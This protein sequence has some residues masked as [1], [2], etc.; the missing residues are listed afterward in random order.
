MSIPICVL[1]SNSGIIS[2]KSI[3]YYQNIA[4]YIDKKR[5]TLKK[6]TKQKQYDFESLVTLP[7]VENSRIIFEWFSN[8]S[9]NDKVTICSIHNKWLAKIINQLIIV[10]EYENSTSL[11]P[12]GDFRK[13]FTDKEPSNNY[14]F[15]GNKF[16]NSYSNT[17][18]PEGNDISFFRYFFK[19]TA[20]AQ[21]KI[22]DKYNKS[23]LNN[24]KFFNYEEA[25]DT[26][27]ISKYLLSKVDDFKKYFDFYSSHNFLKSSIEPD[28]S[29]T[30]KLYN[31]K[32]P[33]WLRNKQ[34]FTIF[35]IIVGYI[36]QNILLNYE[37]YYY[38]KKIYDNK[39][40]EKINEIEELNL[41][42]E[43][44]LSQEFKDKDTF[45]SKINNLQIKKRVQE[46]PLL[47]SEFH[48]QRKMKCDIFAL[49]SNTD[50]KILES[51][52]DRMI[53][54]VIKKMDEWFQ[55]SISELLYNLCFVSS[56]DVASF[57]RPLYA[58]TFS[59]LAQLFQNKNAN[60]LIEE[61]DNQIKKKKKHKKKKKKNEEN[62]TNK[63]NNINNDIKN[64]NETLDN[65]IN[66]IE[67][68]DDKEITIIEENIIQEK[69]L[70][71][72]NVNTKNIIQNENEDDKTKK[73]GKK[74]KQKKE[75]FLYP[76]HQ[77]KKKKEEHKENEKKN[78]FGKPNS[79][80]KTIKEIDINKEKVLLI[81][82]SPQTDNSTIE[83]SE[84]YYSNNN[85]KN[86]KIIYMNNNQYN[87]FYNPYYTSQI[88]AFNI[89][90]NICF[91]IPSENFFTKLTLELEIYNSNVKNNISKLNPIKGIYLE[92]L[93]KILKQTLTNFYNIEIIHFG[94]YKTELSIEGSDI[95]IL[96]KYKPI[97]NQ[98]TFVSDLI[99]ILYQ[100][101]QEFDYIKPITT[102]SVPVIK[103]QFDIT[104]L[105]NI[106]K[107]DD[108]LDY[109]D[110]NK[111]KFDI[112]FKESD[113]YNNN[114]DKTINFIKKS[115]FD[116]PYV[117]DIVLLMK[118]YFKI[119]KLNKIYLGGL[120]SYSIFLMT[121]AFLKSKKYSKEI[122]IGKQFYYFIEW[123]TLFNFT[124][125]IIDVTQDAPFIKIDEYIKNDKITII[126]PINQSNV[127]KS[128]FKIEEI[129]NAFIKVFNIIKIDAWNMEQQKELDINNINNPLKILNTIFHIK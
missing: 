89:L 32:F 52:T 20:D 25:N 105:I 120:S 23:F 72:I 117:K 78:E 110:L 38:S 4:K 84:E 19:N 49:I 3:Q 33:I 53:Y 36:E 65:I 69:E 79:M 88:L 18:L 107:I 122:S 59:Y 129:K 103:L 43:N 113:F 67:Q 126:D 30:H 7:S 94:S 124:E 51:I 70:D 102:A 119:I 54:L 29:L 93:D 87:Y 64:D 106:N 62:N 115:I 14:Y 99:G 16:S 100:N 15:D 97:Q 57:N 28:Y 6:N 95:D 13:F 8:L 63:E 112:S 56:E 5:N 74:K 22:S 83:T 58:C 2:N 17:D 114:F 76:T 92:K 77:S 12:V 9:L 104:K 75:F 111:L 10:Y 86:N 108:Y 81:S 48:Y 109:D 11:Y 45:Y 96:I 26:I 71:I 47:L 40:I 66:I 121:L 68:K 82:N 27:T 61:M 24:I 116:F 35:E 128:S 101:K 41:K 60:E 37:Y 118:R 85:S 98:N 31:F 125:F 1:S 80:N 73:K 55:N 91:F 50:N 90:K 42:L 34:N 39:L 127:S 44:F 21:N 123:Y 46:N